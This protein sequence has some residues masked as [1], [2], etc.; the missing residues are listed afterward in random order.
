MKLFKKSP[1]KA[2][3]DAAV[4]PPPSKVEPIPYKEQAPEV[5]ACG[6]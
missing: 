6:G 4:T 3:V 5:R 2:K 1:R